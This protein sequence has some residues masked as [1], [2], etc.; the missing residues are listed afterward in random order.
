M[1]ALD[2]PDSEL[3]SEND[4]RKIEEKEGNV[5]GRSGDSEE[6]Y[7]LNCII[8]VYDVFFTC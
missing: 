8:T 4:H 6:T 5:Q 3:A 1:S 7:C 2:S